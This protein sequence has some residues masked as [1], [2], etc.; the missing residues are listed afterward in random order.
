MDVVSVICKL[1][2]GTVL[3]AK[4]C[5]FCRTKA[6]F[7]EL[8]LAHWYGLIPCSKDGTR[9]THVRCAV[10]VKYQSSG[11]R[12]ENIGNVSLVTWMSTLMSMTCSLIGSIKEPLTMTCTQTVTTLSDMHPD[13]DHPQ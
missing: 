7:I 5:E 10:G 12:C 3:G 9:G 1:L 13:S 4:Y 2:G 8:C 6:T 11:F